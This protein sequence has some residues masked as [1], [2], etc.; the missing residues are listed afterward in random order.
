MQLIDFLESKLHRYALPN[1]TY[2]L[3]AGQFLAFITTSIKPET[4]EY[5]QLTGAQLLGGQLWRAITFLFIPLETSYI[6][7]IFFYLMYY[8]FGTALE[9]YWG[10]TRYNLF[11]G[12]SILATII[13]SLMFPTLPFTGH[14]IYLSI[15]LAFAYL[16]PDHVLYIFFILPVKIK[17]LAYFFWAFFAWSLITSP[18]EYKLMAIITLA[19]FF[20]FFGDDLLATLK[21]RARNKKNQ[22]T[23]TAKYHHKCAVCGKTDTSDPDADFRYCPDCNPPK[24]YC[25]DH[26]TDHKHKKST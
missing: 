9:S 25:Q 13:A 14:Y 21:L 2:A 10:T 12:I 15:F 16:N 4:I 5:Y 22:L 20:L 7:A 23:P 18:I 1:L 17:W 19:N 24:P 26:I 11:I 8:H 3:L 6:F